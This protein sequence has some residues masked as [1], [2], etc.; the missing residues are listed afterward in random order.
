M[1]EDL[2][3]IPFCGT[4]IC[5]SDG[6]GGTCGSCGAK[7]KCS[8]GQCVTDPTLGCAGLDLAEKWNGTFKGDASFSPASISL[9]PIKTSTKGKM[10]FAIKCFNSKFLVSGTMDGEASGNK[11]TLTL[12]G[13]YDPTTKALTGKLADG[14][15]KMWL[16][17]EYKFD[18]PITGTLG[19]TPTAPQFDG[20]WSV[21]TSAMT[22][23]GSPANGMAPFT[24]SGTWS[25]IPGP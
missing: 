25:A 13:T 2:G 24:A 20:V 17:L 23:L 18:G 22:L 6:C 11:F 19:G 3:C 4:K 21:T 7:E 15:I 12:D 5:G 1:Q 8:V 14:D 10:S 16:V 9:V